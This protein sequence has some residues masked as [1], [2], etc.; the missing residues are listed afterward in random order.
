MYA[1]TDGSV[2]GTDV[3]GLLFLLHR[4]LMMLVL[5]FMR[6]HVGFTRVSQHIL[7]FLLSKPSRTSIFMICYVP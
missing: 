4:V 3:L 7:I 2:E 1:S 6:V 5:K